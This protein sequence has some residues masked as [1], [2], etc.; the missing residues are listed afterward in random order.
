MPKLFRHITWN[1]DGMTEKNIK[2]RI[3]AVCNLILSEKAELIF[4][5]EV[6]SPCEMIIRENLGNK[7]EIFS[8]N[9]DSRVD[10]YYIMTLVAKNSVFKVESNQ[11]LNFRQTQMSRNIIK[12]NVGYSPD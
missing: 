5:Q 9:V 10:P 11:I 7:F 4:L 3:T 8:G 1:I 6:T 2:I 12:T